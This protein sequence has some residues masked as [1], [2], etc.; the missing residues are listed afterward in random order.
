MLKFIL[1]YKSYVIGITLGALAGFLYW[2]FVGC[3]TGSCPI[4]SKWYNST[5]YGMVIGALLGSS[6]KK[7]EVE[8]EKDINVL[9]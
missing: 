6:S 4:A 3:S 9:D 7:K 1:K 8:K 5:L 2:R